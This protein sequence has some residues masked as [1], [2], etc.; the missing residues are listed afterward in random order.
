MK[1]PL[2][3]LLLI[4]DRTVCPNL[5]QG[6]AGAL[7][8]GV[9]HLLLREKNRL[10][11]KEHNQ[12]LHQWTKKLLPLTE[13]FKAHLL[14]SASL[15]V[16]L[17]FPGVGLHL[18]ESGIATELAR[19]K[20]GPD[21]LLGRSCHNL[22]GALTALEQGADYLTL[23]PLFATQSHPKATPLGLEKFTRIR[24]AIPGPVLALGGIDAKNLPLA[25]QTGAHGVALIRAVLSAPSPENAS[26]SLLKLMNH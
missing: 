12:R 22:S 21:R 24:A 10:S 13:L 2:P 11:P 20:L 25:L 17:D 5:E 3:K 4:T 16:A 19:Q 7:R 9:R 14:I 18:P 23:S 8:G 6:V 15:E 1:P 26:Y